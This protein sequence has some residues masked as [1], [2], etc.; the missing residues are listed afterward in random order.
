V[1]KRGCT[2]SLQGHRNGA[3]FLQVKVPKVA[4]TISFTVPTAAETNFVV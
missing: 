4:L 2:I 1:G 3:E